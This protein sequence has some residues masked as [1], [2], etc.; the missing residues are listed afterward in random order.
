MPRKKIKKKVFLDTNVILC[1]LSG[2]PRCEGLFEKSARRDYQYV[3]NSVVVQELLY[4]IEFSRTR[5]KI[6]GEDLNRLLARLEVTE[7]GD[8]K[9]IRDLA[10]L[11]KL[12]NLIVHTNDFLNISTALRECDF[13]ITLDRELLKIE[14][15]ERTKLLSPSEFLSS[16][17]GLK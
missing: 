13:F 11:R 16:A 8:E 10:A 1:Y 5:G 7:L 4:A 12:R 6:K 14:R 2:D 9:E 15:L 17:V 3:I